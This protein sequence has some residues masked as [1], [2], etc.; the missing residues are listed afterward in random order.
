MLKKILLSLLFVSSAFGQPTYVRIYDTIYKPSNSGPVPAVRY[1]ITLK[2][3]KKNSTV[4]PYYTGQPFYT[5][6][7]GYVY[8]YVPQNCTIRVV[9]DSYN[10]DG[11]VDFAIGTD[12]SVRLGTLVPAS[13]SAS[14]QAGVVKIEELDGSPSYTI[15]GNNDVLQFSGATVSQPGDDTVLVAITAPPATSANYADSIRTDDGKFD[16]DNFMTSAGLI[17]TTITAIDTTRFGVFIRNHQSAGGGGGSGTVTSVGL[18]MPSVFS[19]ASTPVTTSGTIGVTFATGQTQNRV[20][21][22]PNGASG[23]VTLRAL[24]AAD[25]PDLSS[26]YQPLDVNELSPIAGLTSAADRLPYY[27]G[28]GTAALAVFT[29]AARN[30]IDDASASAMLTTL[31]LSANGISTI[32]ATD[33]AAMRALWDLEAGTDFYSISGADAAFQPLEATLTDI[34]DGTIAENLVNTAN[35]WA[36]NEVADNITASNYTLLSAVRDSITQVILDSLG[37]KFLNWFRNDLTHEALANGDTTLYANPNDGGA[38]YK[39]VYSAAGGGDMTAAVY[40]PAGVTEQLAGLTAIQTM[41]NKT[42]TAPTINGLT[43]EGTSTIGNGATGPGFL[44]FLEDSDN[45]TEYIQLIGQATLGSNFTITLPG[46]TG[47]V[48]LNLSEDSSPQLGGN[49]DLNGN[50]I[51]GLEIGTDVLAQQTIGIANDNLLEVDGTPNSG[52][53]ARFTANGLEGRTESEFKSDFNLEIGTDVLAPNGDGQNVTIDA[54]AFSGNLTTA[55]N[56]LQEVA[57]AFNSYSPSGSDA[58]AIHDNVGGEISA[59]TEK[60]TPIG[61]DLALIEDSEASNAKKSVKLSTVFNTFGIGVNLE[62]GKL[63]VAQDTDSLYS[64]DYIGTATPIATDTTIIIDTDDGLPKKALISTLPVALGQLTGLGTGVP[65]ALAINIGSAGAPV[66][67]NGAGGTP[68][69]MT[70]TN[71]TGIPEAGITFPTNDGSR[72]DHVLADMAGGTAGANAFDFGGAT[73]VEIPNG[74]NPTT[75]AEGEIAYDTDEEGLRIFDGTNDRTIPTI[76]VVEK[77]ILYP[78]SVQARSDDVILY[79]FPAEIYPFGVTVV[80]A[81]ISASASCSDTHVLEE[82]DDAVGSTQATI[83][84]M[85]LSTATKV[86]TSSPTDGALAADSY[87][88]INL[89][90]ATDNLNWIQVTIGYYINPGD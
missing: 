77:T 13:T 45:G 11:T 75:D 69:S 18:T 35:P 20:L 60:T 19:V 50:V 26:V 1:L 15:Q 44:R 54:S 46:I 72:H 81:A 62:P 6:S 80:Y 59:I 37:A 83:H 49:L 21:A 74:T 29:A 42:L 39:G 31:G 78:D 4:I 8:F 16:F 70:G 24:V 90:D 52:E 58:N 53:Y 23:A 2:N 30:L 5:N 10:M 66:L 68:S 89:D 47:T 85:A 17:D 51:T 65:A 41:S 67:F 76:Q 40:D 25:I 79:H 38:I 48:M 63:I 73:S 9:C 86:E 27:T 87:I 84:S 3:V 64:T 34:A 33:Y 28:S 55:D 36:D 12:D 88:N 61:N 7:S 22:S 14:T 43:L 57:A 82:W 32:T 56:T 71:I